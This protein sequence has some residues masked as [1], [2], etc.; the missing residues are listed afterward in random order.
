MRPL[1]VALAVPLRLFMMIVTVIVYVINRSAA[2]LRWISRGAT[3]HVFYPLLVAVRWI[4]GSPLWMPVDLTIGRMPRTAK[5][6]NRARAAGYQPVQCDCGRATCVGTVWI[7][8]GPP[9]TR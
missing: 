5:D 4:E 7:Q 1:R 6:A 8:T 3:G 2:I 9:V